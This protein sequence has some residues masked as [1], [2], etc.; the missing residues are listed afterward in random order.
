MSVSHVPCCRELQDR[1]RTSLTTDF[2]PRSLTAALTD[3]LDLVL[4]ARELKVSWAQIAAILQL[5][6][7][8]EDNLVKLDVATLRGV[9][10]R[11]KRR[12]QTE[13]EQDN[14]DRRVT[15]QRF[16][17]TGKLSDGCTVSTPNAG[18]R[19]ASVNQPRVGKIPQQTTT[20]DKASR[21]AETH[22]RLREVR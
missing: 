18:T 20:D 15:Q 17:A 14:H 11:I 4:A 8:T 16:H 1:F 19:H 22:R 5:P 13:F 10:G 6:T 9:C 12:K 7:E 21:L 2:G 3:I